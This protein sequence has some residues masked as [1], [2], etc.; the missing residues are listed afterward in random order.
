MRRRT[1]LLAGAAGLV[2]LAGAIPGSVQAVDLWRELSGRFGRLPF[3][4][5]FEPAIRCAHDG[6]VVPPVTAFHW[7]R[8]PERYADYPE[9]GELFLPGGRAPIGSV[10]GTV[11]E[12]ME[13][14]A[15]ATARSKMSLIA[16]FL[17][18]TTSR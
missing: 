14:S 12:A 17:L 9:F 1:R 3:E 7:S 2:V 16:R 11:T 5:L 13:A 4:R 18:R 10:P 8:A 6:F 15:S